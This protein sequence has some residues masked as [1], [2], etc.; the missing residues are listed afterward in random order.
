MNNSDLTKDDCLE[1]ADRLFIDTKD[2]YLCS[3]VHSEKKI[4]KFHPRKEI[5]RKVRAD[6]GAIVEV[7][8]DISEDTQY[9]K[10]EDYPKNDRFMEIDPINEGNIKQMITLAGLQKD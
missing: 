10:W 9:E 6:N 7:S 4:Y 2:M 5:V 8:E 3:V 1:I